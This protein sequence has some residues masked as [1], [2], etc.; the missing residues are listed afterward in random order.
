M[1]PQVDAGLDD[2]LGLL[3][4]RK[5]P[6]EPGA[7]PKPKMDEYEKIHRELNFETRAKPQDRLKTEEEVALRNQNFTRRHKTCEFQNLVIHI[8]HGKPNVKFP[9]STL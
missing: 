1:N 3:D 7:E 2:I 9:T 4:F 5:K 6:G 8:P